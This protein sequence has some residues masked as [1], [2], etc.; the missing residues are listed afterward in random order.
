MTLQHHILSASTYTVPAPFKTFAVRSEEPHFEHLARAPYR[1]VHV[2]K[3]L[4]LDELTLQA[5]AQLGQS[6]MHLAAP[7]DIDY[8]LVTRA[9]LA[10]AAA[11][12]PDAPALLRCIASALQSTGVLGAMRG[13]D[14][15]TGDTTDDNHGD[16]YENAVAA[17][18]D[19]LGAW[20]AGFHNDVAGHW[21]RCL[22]WN[23]ALDLADTEFVMPHAKLR[24]PLSNGDLI[25]FDQTMAH[26]LCRSKDQGHFV[27]ASFTTGAAQRQTF[28]SGELLLS[29][30]QWAL[31]GAPWSAL[32]HHAERAALDLLAA[33]F[34]ET[35]GA[36]KGLRALRTRMLAAL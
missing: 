27:E 8:A 1:H 16:T 30:A 20:G 25:V 14:D 33:E 36:I 22:F 6:R 26:G 2:V 23:L 7:G 24:V 15:T 32:G 17:R 9:E 28:L 19:F 11:D 29:S 4:G 13:S 35:S 31:L 10:A 21:P 3:G 18:L 5:L 34:D 12:A